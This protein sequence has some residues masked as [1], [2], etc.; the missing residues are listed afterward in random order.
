[1]EKQPFLSWS[2]DVK[3]NVKLPC[4]GSR[5]FDL[6]FATING[7]VTNHTVKDQWGNPVEVPVFFVTD[8][9]V[10]YGS[11]TTALDPNTVPC[12]EEVEPE[13]EP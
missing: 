7:W 10:T 13:P 5:V 1:M 4:V 6:R 9:G 2:Y 11:T 3:D 8:G 12:C